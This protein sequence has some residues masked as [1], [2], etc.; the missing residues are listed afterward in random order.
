M[1]IKIWINA[2]KETVHIAYISLCADVLCWLILKP[3][4][5]PTNTK[6]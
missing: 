5:D 3:Q 1:G 2:L 4:K 6:H